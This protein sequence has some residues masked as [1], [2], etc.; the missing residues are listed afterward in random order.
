MCEPD[1][2]GFMVC[3]DL[4]DVV[5]KINFYVEIVVDLIF[6][7]FIKISHLIINIFQ[8]LR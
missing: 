4:R 8:V 1:E 5:K 3:E 6:N 2:K 7:L